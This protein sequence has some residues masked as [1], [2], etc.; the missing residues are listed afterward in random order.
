MAKKII[1]DLIVPKKSI[2]QIAVSKETK[3]KAKEI[4]IDYR[5]KYK[6]PATR[7]NRK[8]L[9]PKF[10]IWLLAVICLVALF[11]GVS[12]VFSSATV[13]INP[14]LQALTFNAETFSAKLNATGSNDLAYEVLKIK[15]TA[16]ATVSATAEKEVSKKSTG[17]VI[18]YN[19]YSKL[20]QRLINNTRFES[21]NGKI[22]R[23]SSSVVVPGTKVVA[24]KTIPGSI[25]A[26]LI[27]DQP[28]EE[29]NLFVSDLAGDFKIPGF[30]GS[31][32]YDGFYARIKEDIQ[33]GLV[34]RQKIIDDK[35]RLAATDLLKSDLKEQLLKELYSTKP[36]DYIIL[37]NAYTIDFTNLPDT[38]VDNADKAKIN[39]EGSINSI[40]FNNL[41]LSKYIAA[42]KVKDYDSL[43][44][45]LIF[46]D[47]LTTS[48]TGKETVLWKNISVDLKLTGT[49]NLKWLYDEEQ[50][51]RDLA[52]RKEADL[53]QILNKYRDSISSLR[54]TFRPVWT[55]YF[56]DNLDKITT[57]ETLGT[58]TK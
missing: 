5:I 26:T 39:I 51:K 8:P 49:A 10:I 44:V 40:V 32:R 45:S 27:A 54:V 53:E 50:I 15:K 41:K 55:R 16:T 14:R 31:P 23:L 3:Q 57:E 47:S 38:F 30:K 25:E 19:N 6:I 12:L 46:T 11:F 36:D 13:T 29:Y 4:K 22:Y 48:L 17:K 24:G 7:G 2:R 56:P 42:K 21:K 37:N 28:G 1:S 43:P 58:L 20:T 35:V 52:G 34:G 9:N 33:G 18:I